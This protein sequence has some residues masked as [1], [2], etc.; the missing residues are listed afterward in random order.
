M[1]KITILLAATAMLCGCSQHASL[2][3]VPGV[4]REASFDCTRT[5]GARASQS[6]VET[7]GPDR[8][9]SLVLTSDQGLRQRLKPVASGPNRLFASRRYAWKSTGSTGVLTDVENI[10]SYHCR[11]ILPAGSLRSPAWPR[12][13]I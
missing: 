12:G 13:R 2:G 1:N 10:L 4:D 6:V 5:D 7:I 3:P 9:G 8:D 11:E